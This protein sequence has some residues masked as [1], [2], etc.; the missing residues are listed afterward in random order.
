[1]IKMTNFNFSSK[2]TFIYKNV[3]PFGF[4][5]HRNIFGHATR[6]AI[7]P[8]FAKVGNAFPVRC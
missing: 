7:G 4:A 2:L 8:A 5:V 6:N 3:C 1:M